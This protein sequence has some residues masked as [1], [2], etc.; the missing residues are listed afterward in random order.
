[1]LP[2]SCF[3]TFTSTPDTVIQVC[4]EPQIIT[5]S[6]PAKSTLSSFS[7]YL[8]ISV[9]LYICSLFFS[10]KSCVGLILFF[11]VTLDEF[12]LGR[13]LPG[14]GSSS[15]GCPDGH[16]Q[17]FLV[18][19][20]LYVIFSKLFTQMTE[21]KAGSDPPPGSGSGSGFLCGAASNR[22]RKM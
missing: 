16:L 9:C 21:G 3:L 13:F 22:T 7:L 2:F 1:M 11:Q 20:T 8:F 14:P 10:P 6:S 19:Y 15:P 5:L 4:R 17:V 18:I 12:K